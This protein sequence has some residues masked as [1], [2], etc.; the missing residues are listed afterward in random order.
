[1]RLEIINNVLRK[2][3]GRSYQKYRIYFYS[4]LSEH[5][6]KSVVNQPLLIL[7]K[8]IIDIHHSV[9]LGVENSPGFYSNYSYIESRHTESSIRIGE[10]TIINNDLKIISDC[11]NILIGK[12]CLIGSNFQVLNSN[13][14]DLNPNNRFN[15]VTVLQDNVEIGNNVFIGNNVTVLK[16]VSI[17]CNSIIANG[18][19]VVKSI[20]VNSVAGGNPAKIIGCL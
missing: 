11:K 15:T 18:S 1:M 7:G 9:I 2:I 14:H 17:G 20:P 6:T 12:S 5:K 8:G 16:G 10:G 4:M 19:V 13:F 3:I